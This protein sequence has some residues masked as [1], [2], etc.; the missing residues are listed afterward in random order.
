MLWITNIVLMSHCVVVTSSTN[1]LQKQSLAPN[2]RPDVACEACVLTLNSLL[3][4]LRPVGARCCWTSAARLKQ[5]ELCCLWLFVSQSSSICPQSPVTA[6]LQPVQMLLCVG[7]CFTMLMK[8]SGGEIS[9]FIISTPLIIVTFVS[10]FLLLLYLWRRISGWIWDQ[11]T[12]ERQ[13]RRC[14][15][16]DSVLYAFVDSETLREFYSL[17]WPRKSSFK[18]Q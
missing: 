5:A 15:R 4:L 7:F 12:R 6:G 16:Y 1:L 3:L 11:M 8:E 9:E 10:T 2:S 17:H 14:C 13:Q 18:D